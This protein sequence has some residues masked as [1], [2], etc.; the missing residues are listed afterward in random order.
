[1]KHYLYTL[2]FCAL[3][4]AGWA[5]QPGE[6]PTPTEANPVFGT[7]YSSHS[8]TLDGKNGQSLELALSDIIYAHTHKSY[9]QLWT[10][11]ETTDM[12][13]N[14]LL[15]DPEHADQVYD[16]YADFDRFTKYYSDKNI[17]AT[18]AHSQTGGI[19]R[20]HCVPNSWWGGNEGN[21]VAYTDLHH[22]VPSDGAANNAKQN[23]PLG[24][25][26][27]GMT[28]TWPTATRTN[29]AGYIYVEADNT[30]DHSGSWS[31]VWNTGS[32]AS[33][34]GN[35]TRVFEPMDDYKG[36]FARMY[37]Y[38]VCAYEGRV[39][40]QT[41]DNTVFSN[42][43]TPAD[44]VEY[45][46]T[47]ISDWAQNLLLE[48]HR[49]DPVSD[50]ERA[51]NNAV[52]G[53][54]GN[55]NPFI[56]YPEL[57]E[58]IWGN[59]STQSFRLASAQSAY[60]E[61]YIQDHPEL[62][63]RVKVSSA[64]YATYFNSYYAYTMPDG[65]EGYRASINSGTC[66]FIKS[67]EPGD[68]VPAGEPLLLKAAAGTYG[69]TRAITSDESY[70]N[71]YSNDFE[72]AAY[73]LSAAQMATANPTASKYYALMNG[74]HGVGFYW[75]NATGN[76]FDI[77]ARRVYLPVSS[78]NKAAFII[79]DN[80]ITDIDYMPAHIDWTKPVFNILGQR[81]AEGTTGLL[82]Q[83]GHKFFVK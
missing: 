63:G 77:P 25:Y 69:L 44:G 1:M 56:D 26:Q 16:M 24:E 53:I 74:S 71:T 13:P 14:Y 34:F 70:K 75:A 59:Q 68:A 30:D 31:H 40:W 57:A 19:N 8:A 2:I 37:L 81:V 20:E 10:L 67:Y 5:D 61:A 49:Q 11:F 29:N 65:M 76:A 18:A 82:I 12:L 6:Q 7:Y 52:F 72:G 28:L 22:L 47:T 54:Q 4:I 78:D 36:D 41:T 43:S 38:V 48:W 66:T 33:Q 23:Y 17:D 15:K 32:V 60:T 27:D 58:Y 64:G 21:S 35:A 3:P 55:R 50:K 62:V 39:Q 46:Y 83:E 80:E 79:E 9:D 51:R 45:G 73:A 42:Q